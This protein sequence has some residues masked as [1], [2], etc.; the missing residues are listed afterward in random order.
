MRP[1]FA[2]VQ[3]DREARNALPMRF[4]TQ[5]IACCLKSRFLNNQF[6]DAERISQSA[7]DFIHQ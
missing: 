1:G 6:R 2:T 5:I 3:G 7:G 4:A